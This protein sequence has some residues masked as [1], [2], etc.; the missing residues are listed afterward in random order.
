MKELYEAEMRGRIIRSGIIRMSA[1]VVFLLL[2]WGAAIYYSLKLL[3]L[4]TL[5]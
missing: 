3:K 5:V 4:L 2:F 1:I